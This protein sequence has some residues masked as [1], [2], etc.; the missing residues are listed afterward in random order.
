VEA[1]AG[2]L[3]QKAAD[4]T[5]TVYGFG[6]PGKGGSHIWFRLLPEIWGCGGDICDTDLKKATL[7]TSAV[8][9]ALTYY[10]DMYKKGYSPKSMLENDATATSQMFA[11][12]NVAMAIENV[13]WIKNNVAD[14]NLFEVGIAL[15]PG[16]N[17]TN[18][19]GLGGW[20]ACIPSSAKNKEGGA[21]FIN[22]VTGFEGM[23]RQLM[24]PALAEVLSTSDWSGDFFGPYTEML[25][26]YSRDFPAFE[27]TAAAQNILMNMVQSVIT[28]KSSIDDAVKAANEEIQELLD[29]QNS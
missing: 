8:K 18:T 16:K 5:T 27:N 24:M 26:K 6:L 17:G 23:K 22:L 9:E 3:T 4:G 28:G 25:A 2:K 1:A 19:A 12:G 29:I 20:N 13:T 7:D 11:S 14:K 21:A 10:T 15:Y